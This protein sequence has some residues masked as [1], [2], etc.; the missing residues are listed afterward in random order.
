M[1]EF[2]TNLLGNTQGLAAYLSVFGVLLACGLGVP[3]PEDISLILGGYLAHIGAASLPIMMAVGFA[4]IIVGDS[5]IFFAGRRVG[6]RVSDGRHGFL[7][8][9]VTPEK[10]ARVEGLFATHGQKIVMIARFLPGVRAVTYFTAGSAGMSYWR[11]VF[12]DGVAALASAPLFVYL[13]YRFG[14]ELDV[15]TGKL[16]DGQIVVIGAMVAAAVAFFI[17]RRRSKSKARAALMAPVGNVSPMVS[18]SSD[19][20]A[21][22][23][24]GAPS[25]SDNEP[26][27]RDRAEPYAP[28]RDGGQS[29][30][31][32]GS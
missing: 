23:S 26:R 22:M 6:S 19:D 17:Y 4:G 16:K 27:A 21:A 13:G 24:I 9:I 10:R 2:L 30:L 5:L 3:L 14:G 7:A 1:E 11:F 20:R 29:G 18:E 8:R 15:L 28:P 25:E 31:S 12:F 32:V